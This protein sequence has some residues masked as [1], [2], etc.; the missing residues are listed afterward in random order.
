M[1]KTEPQKI[2]WDEKIDRF[3]DLVRWE[4]GDTSGNERRKIKEI[5]QEIVTA[6]QTKENY[7]E[8]KEHLTTCSLCLEAGIE[9][10]ELVEKYLFDKENKIDK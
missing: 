9:H 3:L 1:S 8:L 2:Q 5:K 10:C 4:D 7:S 6:L